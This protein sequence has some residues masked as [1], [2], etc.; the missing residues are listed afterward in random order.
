MSFAMQ[1]YYK[2]FNVASDMLIFLTNVSFLLKIGLL[3]HHCVVVIILF[4][5]NQSMI[6]YVMVSEEKRC[7]KP[8]GSY[9]GIALKSC[10]SVASISAFRY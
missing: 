3:N 10:A 9:F 6:R 5:G 8:V 1:N 4:N 2:Y 7:R